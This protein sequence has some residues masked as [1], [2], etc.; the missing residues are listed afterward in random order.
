ME[1][2]EKLQEL[3]K[4]KGLTQQ[5]LAS[6]LYVSRTAVSKWELGKGYP[7]IDTLK[8]IAKY[9]SITVD[10]LLSSNE[11][12]TVAENDVKQKERNIRS[13]IFG[14]LDTSNFLLLFLPLFGQK[15]GEKIISVSLLDLT[16]ISMWLKITYFSFLIGTAAFGILT[17]ALQNAS[18]MFWQQSKSKIS[19]IINTGSTLLFILSTQPYTAAL[20]LFFLII[21]ASLLLKRR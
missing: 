11:V 21:K 13:L 18:N 10:E 5:E 8:S 20:S 9:F 15:A 2:N 12:L 1:F 17:L 14:L 6:A 16:E 19:L 4:R 3:R 7:S